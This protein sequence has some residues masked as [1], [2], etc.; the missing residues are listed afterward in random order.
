MSNPE[1]IKKTTCAF[2]TN[3]CGVL[4]HV[5]DGKAVKCEGNPDHF[6]SQG[7]TCQRN[8]LATRWLYHPGQ[9]MHPLKRVGKRGEGKWQRISWDDALG[10]IGRKLLKLKQ[11][12]GAQTVGVVGGEDKGNN[13][14]PRGRFLSL[15]G[16][17]Y[18]TFS[19]G[20]MCGVNDMA[21]NRAVLGDDSSHT[22][23]AAGTNCLVIWGG[24]PSESNHRAWA[25]ILKEKRERDI[26]VIVV[27]PRQ[28]GTTKIANVWLQPRPGTDTALAMAWLNVIINEELYE[29]EF[30][31]KWTVGFDKL[32]TRVQDY[33]PDKCAEITGIPVEKIVES[34]RMYATGKPSSIAYGVAADH[35][36]VNGTRTEHARIILRAITGNLG[37]FGGELIV[38]PGET[39]NGGKFITE[40][41]LTMIEKVPIE[42]RK[43]QLGAD[44]SRLVSLTGW[45]MTAEYVEKVYG[46]PAAVSYQSQA[47]VPLLWRAILSGRPYP[48][49]AL[50]TWGSNPLTSMGNIRLVYNALKSDNLEL[51][52][53]HELVMTPT[54]QLADYVLPAA[55]WLER[56]ICTNMG[57]YV[58]LI[59]GG[60]KA[61]QPLGERRDVYQLFRGLGRAVGQDE[62][63]PWQ[64]T[65][66][67][68]N[69]RLK[70]L[71][72]TF[73]DLVDR[74]VLFPDSFEMQ[75]WEK[76]GF[77][78][79]SGKIELY[80]TILEK[81][82]YDPL[83]HYQEPPESPISTPDVAREY[84]LIFN[85]GGRFM[86][87]HHSEFMHSEL[88]R[89][90]HP[91]PL[92]DI[93]PDTARDLGIEDGD[94]AYI[95]TRRGRIKQRARHNPGILH[96]V[97]NCQ[98]A[99]WFPEMTANEPGL[100][101]LWESNA[102]VLTLDEPEACDELSGGWCVRALLC[103]VY[104]A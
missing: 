42:D 88:G 89:T 77:P 83:P 4:V 94:L 38:R 39:I 98:S 16:N 62:H 15:F 73:R 59:F 92:M 60:E 12:H 72:L 47:H 87:M 66:E 61:V 101:G 74:M 13:Y 71:G 17:P 35:F 24:D 37:V 78:T 14:W 95:E 99:W 103:K 104:R 65:E 68:S 8:R 57:D 102:N 1:E 56:D 5:E 29:K 69:Y 44:L 45:G 31:E 32:K 93:H 100:S 26:K 81:L 21:I 23:S 79:P 76:T 11:E 22:G 96:N 84:P 9:L 52:V 97:I 33:P 10:E 82:G 55:S 64:T 50:I 85:T 58:S 75:P 90:S 86:P 63:W 53:I 43:K 49:K 48:M 67:V 54:A 6:V 51:H 19:H 27:D 30:V 70:P 28:T 3:L 40:A 36:G 91:D 34:A 20:V 25:T 2:C 7:F 80:S 46:V 18:N 41:E